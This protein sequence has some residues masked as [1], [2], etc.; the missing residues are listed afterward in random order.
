MIPQFNVWLQ[1]ANDYSNQFHFF[2]WELEFPEIFFDRYGQY[3]GVKAGFDVVIGN[4][5]YDV[6]KRDKS[7]KQLTQ[8]IDYVREHPRYKPAISNMLN[9]FQLMI[10]QGLSLTM[11]GGAV[12][13]ITPMSLLSDSST[14][15][16][17]RLLIEKTRISEVQAFPQKDDENNRVFQDAKLSTAIFVAYTGLQT[18][19]LVCHVHSGRQIDKNSP[20]LE[21]KIADIKKFD[22]ENLTIPLAS[23]EEIRILLQLYSQATIV[24]FNKILS[25]SVGE[26]DMTQDRDCVQAVPGSHE[27]IKGAHLQRYLQRTQPKQGQREWINMGAFTKKYN[28]ASA[29][30][31]L[32]QH[33]R[34]AFQAITGTDDSR[35]L[36]ATLIPPGYFLANSLNYFSL[37]Q[38]Q[39]NPLFVLALFN[40]NL[41]E[42]RFR[43]TS[44]NNNVNNYQV[45]ALPFR[46]INFDTLWWPTLSRH[47][48]RLH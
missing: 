6:L 28:A 3:K 43:L 35:R 47:K 12:S 46:L 42:W 5:P 2:H 37:I 13:Q 22:P 29:K 36:K 15:G 31:S 30:A 8:F 32:F 21:I 24:P 41:L 33:E 7:K 45:E 44:T 40:S 26:I 34:V 38:Q 16:T 27:L 9:I 25:V 48:S 17:R 19:T 14:S 18:Q 23:A 11:P 20:A 10:V 39:L 1:T 4:P